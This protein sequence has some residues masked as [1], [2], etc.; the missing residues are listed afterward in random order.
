MSKKKSQGKL[1]NILRQMKMKTY[2]N[3]W[4]ATKAVLRGQFIAG[5]TYVKGFP[6]GANG[7]KPTCQYRGHET[8]VRSLSREDRLEKSTATHY[9][10]LAWRIAMDRGTQWAT[11]HRVT[12][13]QTRLNQINT[14]APT[15][16]KKRPKISNQ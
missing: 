4:A 11:V 12:K 14:H 7:K 2:Q 1:E 5:N 15:F 13:S 9:R 6:G 16:K 10:I 8:Q 3:S